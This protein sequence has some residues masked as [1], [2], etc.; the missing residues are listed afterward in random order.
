VARAS[1]PFGYAVS[2]VGHHERQARSCGYDYGRERDRGERYGYSGV[3]ESNPMSMPGT[4]AR[5]DT[6]PATPTVAER[7][8]AT[9]A[10]SAALNIAAPIRCT[11]RR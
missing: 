5:V 8:T 7:T 3:R 4:I 2:G 11:K 1:A 6:T 9:A 10:A